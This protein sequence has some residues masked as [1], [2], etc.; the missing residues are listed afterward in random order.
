MGR[1]KEQTF[2]QGK[3]IAMKRD[4]GTWKSAH[5]DQGTWKSAFHKGNA[6]Q[7][8]KEHAYA[9]GTAIKTKTK[10]KEIKKRKNNNL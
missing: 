2:F 7:N 6:N 9:A 3:N 1:A 8:C 4:Q 5:Q 10:T